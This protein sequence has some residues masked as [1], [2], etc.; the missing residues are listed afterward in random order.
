M[1]RLS[2]LDNVVL[3]SFIS[4]T[5]P[6]A[7]EPSHCNTAHNCDALPSKYTAKGI[8]GRNGEQAKQADWIDSSYRHTP[9]SRSGRGSADQRC[10]CEGLSCRAQFARPGGQVVV[11]P[12][13][14]A[15][16]TQMLVSAVARESGAT[17]D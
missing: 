4:W 11:L 9:H 5:W 1:A 3:S 10:A 2:V 15:Y 14:L 7:R 8:N 6:P 12:I 13:R 17:D 16:S